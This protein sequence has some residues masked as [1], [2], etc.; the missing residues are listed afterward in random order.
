MQGINALQERREQAISAVLEWLGDWGTSQR[1][2]RGFTAWGQLA[3]EAKATADLEQCR[4]SEAKLQASFDA[5]MAASREDLE[6]RQS[7]LQSRA[8]KLRLKRKREAESSDAIDAMWARRSCGT[9]LASTFLAWRH[10]AANICRACV[11]GASLDR[12]SMHVVMMQVWFAW[13]CQVSRSRYEDI[14]QEALRKVAGMPE[15]ARKVA[16]KHFKALANWVSRMRAEA[17]KTQVLGLALKTWIESARRGAKWR[18]SICTLL[19]VGPHEL[20]DDEALCRALAAWKVVLD[21]A[22]VEHSMQQG[23]RSRRG[24]RAQIRRV[25]AKVVCEDHI[26]RLCEAFLCW[27]ASITDERAERA[28]GQIQMERS[29]GSKTADQ[30]EAELRDALQKSEAWHA[31]SQQERAMYTAEIEASKGKLAEV[32]EA[33]EARMKETELARL[34]LN[35]ATREVSRLEKQVTVAESHQAMLLRDLQEATEVRD[36]AQAAAEDH[37]VAFELRVREA[38]LLTEELQ[39]SNKLD[40]QVTYEGGPPSYVAR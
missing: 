21:A 19:R 22:R 34:D 17:E 35:A 23:K 36:E 16:G 39:I 27:Q 26:P 5:E 10:W 11:R 13:L 29:E 7:H 33:F 6:L 38:S 32:R 18:R 4:S 12:A 25:A 14:E 24:L 1:T 3:A 40:Q 9:L 28:I 2:T 20:D 31:V 30:A 8:A 15:A 37:V